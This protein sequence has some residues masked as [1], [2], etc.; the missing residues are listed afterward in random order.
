MKPRTGTLF[1][2]GFVM[3]AAAGAVLANFRSHQRLGNPGV[4]THPLPNSI[5]LEVEVPEKVLDYQS[6]WVPVDPV[7][8]NGLPADTSFGN[9]LYRAPDGFSPWIQVVLMGNDR[10]SLHKPQFC[11][12]GQAWRIDPAA[13]AETTVRIER[14]VA[15]DLPVVK[16][17]ANRETSDGSPPARL[18]Y[19]Y[20]YVADNAVSASVSGFERMWLMGK[21]LLKT[22]V[23]Q[24]WAYVTCAAAC[25]PG[26]EE[27]TFERLKRL[28][29][30]AVPQLHRAPEARQGMRTGPTDAATIA[31]RN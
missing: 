9:R 25:A 15:Y 20:W 31:G 16:L 13:S 19:V 1:V 29:A 4:R 24:R 21:D 8:S 10:T 30:D 6:E 23:L 12:E 2:I 26:Q 27:V 17:I 14:P 11:L 3:M 7:S 5:R 28:I 18:V 22:G